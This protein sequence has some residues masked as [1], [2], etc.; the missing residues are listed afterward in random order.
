MISSH[1][2]MKTIHFK[3]IGKLRDNFVIGIGKFDGI[4]LGHREILKVIVNEANSK[5]FIPAL[6]TFRN[7]PVEFFL[8]G[9]N[10]KLSLLKEYGIKLC[11]W[12][13]LDEISYLSPE[14]FLD[15]LISSGVRTLV[16]GYDFHFGKERKGN[17]KFLKQKKEEKNFGLVVVPPQKINGEVVKSAEIRRFIK[18]GEMQK[19]SNFLGR[20]FSVTGK[21]IKGSSTGRK[22][23]FPTANLVLEN[24]IQIGEGVYAGWAEYKGKVYK[25]AIVTG[26][27]PTFEDRI[28]K[29]EVFIIDFQQSHDIYDERVKVFFYKKIREQKKFPDMESL[30]DRI[31]ADVREITTILD[32][33]PRPVLYVTECSGGRRFPVTFD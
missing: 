32:S 27:S 12:C 22:L 18:K 2:E 31:A 25:S 28:S 13:D 8:C 4:H 33:Q 10:E 17:I 26:V 6:F 20:Y 21:V 14:E 23:G 19:T 1:T 5:G 24:R 29:F 7:F 30:K 3:N 16:V 15:I 9:W 11:L